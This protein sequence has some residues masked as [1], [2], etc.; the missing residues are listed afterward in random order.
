MYRFMDSAKKQASDGVIDILQNLEPDPGR[1][2]PVTFW[3][4]SDS[5]ANLYHTAHK[6]QEEHYEIQYCG[7]SGVSDDWL[8][9]AEKEI[10]P[11]P[12]IIEHLFYQFEELAQQTG[13]TF[14]G[15]ETRIEME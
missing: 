5:E 3:F 4:Y 12:D 6:L 1:K 8:L 13:V 15:W 14:D 7:K 2:R 11:R 9:I 10:S